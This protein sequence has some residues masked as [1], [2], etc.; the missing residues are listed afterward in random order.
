M[1]PIL[2]ILHLKKTYET[3]QKIELL[4]DITFTIHENES[5]AIMGASGEGKT[6]L[7]HILATLE[8]PTSGEILYKGKSIYSYK[9]QDYRLNA[10]GFIF[11]SY[12]LIE[13]LSV[14][15]NILLP[16]RLKKEVSKEKAL[17]LLNE[18]GLS[19]KAH[20]LAKVLSGGE[21]Q[22]AAIAR[23]FACDPEMIF[24]D[25]P[26]GNLDHANAEKIHRFLLDFT[27]KMKKTLVIATH[28]QNLAGGCQ[29]I[30]LL[31]DGI[32]QLKPK[33]GS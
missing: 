30:Y 26:T 6:T 20:T 15:E 32:I 14:L 29:T 28:N 9:E 24:A 10:I 19:S 7:L 1:S 21:K 13:D 33:S 31:Q 3:L 17:F 8:K 27:H 22:R 18:V 5:I 4:K 16:M 12:N 11:Q 23:A 2:T 25:E